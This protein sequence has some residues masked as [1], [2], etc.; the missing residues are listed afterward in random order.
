MG[1][2]ASTGCSP[3]KEVNEYKVLEGGRFG[4]ALENKTM[5]VIK[6]SYFLDCLQQQKPFA[7][8]AQ[9]EAEAPSSIYEG[10]EAAQKWYRYQHG[11]LIVVSYCWL[12]KE[13]PD[14]KMFYL[15]YLK[16]VI[17]AMKSMYGM[18]QVGII[19]DYT[20]F[21]QEPRTEDQLKS[22]K[23]CLNLINVPYGHHGVLAVKFV[24]VPT[25]EKRTYDDR[26]WTKFES[27]V[28]DSKPGPEWHGEPNVITCS[29]MTD[30]D[31]K[32]M[33]KCQRRPPVTPSRFKAEMEERR[34]RAVGKGVNLFTNGKDQAFLE[35]KYTETFAKMA[36]ASTDLSYFDMNLGDSGVEQLCEV[37]PY[38]RKLKTLYLN[39]NH[40]T[41]EGAKSLAKALAAGGA[42]KLEILGLIGNN[43]GDGAREELSKARTKLK[44]WF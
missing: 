40:I 19:W 6:G 13:H 34:Q 8:R 9:I 1:C 31:L 44:I 16:N 7:H 21:Y 41:E 30:T 17:E 24:T 5:A 28:I 22:F 32:A 3:F 35:D 43:V 15:P 23:E 12:S 18:D 11:W 37:L 39:D 4:Q 20:S 27:D 38:F 2:G 14:P 33:S 42:P 25:D 10:E 29:S 36:E 26:G